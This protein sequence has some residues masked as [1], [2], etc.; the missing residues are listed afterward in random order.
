MSGITNAHIFRVGKHNGLDFDEHSLDQIVESFNE[1]GL[2]KRVPL[3]F[4][5]TVDDS[6]PALGW[7]DKIWRSGRELYANFVDMGAEVIAK[8]RAGQYRFTSIELLRDSSYEGKKYPY[9]LDGVALLGAAPPAVDGLTPLDKSLHS[10]A[11]HVGGERLA[12]SWNEPPADD[13][14]AALE[15]ANAK[16]KTLQTALDASKIENLQFSKEREATAKREAELE[17]ERLAFTAQREREAQL[18]LLEVAVRDRQITP[19]QREQYIKFAKL[20]DASVPLRFS[21]DE[22]R[23]QIAIAATKQ[24]LERMGLKGEVVAFSAT[25][26]LDVNQGADLKTRIAQIQKEN[27]GQDLG[28]VFARA[29]REMPESLQTQ[30]TDANFEQ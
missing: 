26:P 27:P 5:H 8:I 30:F 16:L 18:Q 12:F 23:E 10:R 7:V 20:N 25:P 2:S 29:M 3:R 4:G 19:G 13:S 28:I 1:A 11:A 22:M 15:A 6:Q 21:R 24:V 9:L 14:A 17:A